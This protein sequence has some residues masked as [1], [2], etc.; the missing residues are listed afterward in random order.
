MSRQTMRCRVCRTER[1]SACRHRLAG[2][3]KKRTR[4]Q[5]KRYTDAMIRRWQDPE[6]RKKMASK[7]VRKKW[8][9]ALVRRWKDPKYREYMRERQSK[10]AVKINRSFWKKEVLDR[11][12]RLW[13]MKSQFEVDFAMR[14]DSL[15]V[16]WRYEP[17][18][19]LLSDGRRYTPD[20]WVD[21][22]QTYVELKGWQRQGLD[23]VRL[24]QQDGHGV[25]LFLNGW[26][27]IEDF[28]EVHHG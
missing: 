1:R 15:G 24:A 16:T 8:S 22:W 14:L 9:A 7:K 11:K 26:Q 12:G 2:L 19:L 21:E 25:H 17:D 20:F 18:T 3:G 27:E 6:W 10:S 13:R 4:A 23:K 5:K 28:L